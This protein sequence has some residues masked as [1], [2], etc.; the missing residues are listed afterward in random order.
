M[1]KLG[2]SNETLEEFI[3]R[4][5]ELSPQELSEIGQTKESFLTMAKN[6]EKIRD[7]INYQEL[8]LIFYLRSGKH[9]VFTRFLMAAKQ[10]Y[11][12][13]LTVVKLFSE[14]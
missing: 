1:E 6:C 8:K 9:G 13:Y 14:E 11:E 5:N 2:N 12:A 7:S 10:S 3:A 4:I